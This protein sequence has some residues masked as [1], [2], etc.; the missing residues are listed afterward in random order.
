MDT[1]KGESIVAFLA[2]CMAE[3]FQKAKER[4]ERAAELGLETV[5]DIKRPEEEKRPEEV[6]VRD[7]EKCSCKDVPASGG[8]VVSQYC[9]NELIHKLIKELKTGELVNP[10]AKESAIVQALQHGIMCACTCWAKDPT[11]LEASIVEDHYV[12]LICG[13]NNG[14]D[15]WS[16]YLN[17]LVSIMLSLKEQGYKAWLIRLDNDCPN[18]IW[19]AYIAFRK[20]QA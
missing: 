16:V 7:E 10:L 14:N 4:M 6:V 2:R 15:T 12:A 20:Q 18:D 13:G 5:L 9:N 19:Y 8:C 17:Q 1:N 11:L 3:D